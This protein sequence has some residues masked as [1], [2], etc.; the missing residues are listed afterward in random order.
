M[1]AHLPLFAHPN[2]KSVLIVGGGDGGVLREV[3]RHQG[4]SSITQCDI[5]GKVIE[6][7]K[8]YFGKTLATSFDDERLNL[9][10]GDAAEFLKVRQLI[11]TK[12]WVLAPLSYM[13]CHMQQPDQLEKYDVIIV[14]SSDPV[15][16]ADALFQVHQLLRCQR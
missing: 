10:I 5:D 15:G 12:A 1:I 6:V 3:C 7:A 16:P 2:P 4:V 14:D 13:W 9:V 8:Q 11:V